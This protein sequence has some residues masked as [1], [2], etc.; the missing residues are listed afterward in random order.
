MRISFS[1]I[2]IIITVGKEVGTQ[3]GSTLGTFST[4]LVFIDELK[5]ENSDIDREYI[6]K[7]ESDTVASNLRISKI[8]TANE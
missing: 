7:L 2:I 5:E 8:L 3:I 4:T 6:Q 1:I